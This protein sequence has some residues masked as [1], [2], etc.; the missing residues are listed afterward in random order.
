[1]EKSHHTGEFGNSVSAELSILWMCGGMR[2]NA[3]FKAA[4]A[5]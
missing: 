2:I 1:M 5:A 3:F 4:S